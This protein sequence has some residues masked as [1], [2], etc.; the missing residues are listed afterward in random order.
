M[1]RSA[2]GSGSISAF[3]S[4]NCTPGRVNRFVFAKTT[5]DTDPGI[6]YAVPIDELA[7]LPVSHPTSSTLLTLL[8]L[9]KFW[10][11]PR[12]SRVDSSSEPAPEPKVHEF[13]RYMSLKIRLWSISRAPDA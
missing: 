3:D 7:E 1:R 10:R 8:D 4:M 5:S 13:F 9:M 12:Y 2:L 11:N 6:G